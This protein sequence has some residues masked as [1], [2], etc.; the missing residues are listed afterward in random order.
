MADPWDDPGIWNPPTTPVVDPGTPAPAAPADPNAPAASNLKAKS[1]GDSSSGSGMPDWFNNWFQ[2]FFTSQAPQGPS[3]REAPPPGNGYGSVSQP[4]SNSPLRKDQWS[5]APGGEGFTGAVG[6]PT[7]GGAQGSQGTQGFNMLQNAFNQYFSGGPRYQ[8]QTDQMVGN[9]GDVLKQQQQLPGQIE[10]Q[11]QNMI[12]QLYAGLPR[13]QELYQPA[14]ESMSQRGILNSD[15]TG[16]ALAGIQD[17]VNQ[18]LLQGSAA[19]NTW[20]GGQNIDATK[21]MPQT[22]QGIISTILGAQNN[23]SNFGKD[24]MGAGT[25][26]QTLINQMIDATKQSTSKQTTG[27]ETYNV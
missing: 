13:M 6:S 4:I 11:R 26:Y 1:W 3:F 24:A 20:A 5:A 12:N 17:K 23:Y 16:N 25:S 7:P 21:S 19:A 18:G 15:I 27:S 8:G 2:N 9:L 14:M 22:L 10:T